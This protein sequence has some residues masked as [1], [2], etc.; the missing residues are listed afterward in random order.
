MGHYACDLTFK[1]K[2]KNIKEGQDTNMHLITGVDTVHMVNY[3]QYYKLF[4]NQ[5]WYSLEQDLILMDN[6]FTVYFSE[7]IIW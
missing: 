7:K 2:V 4:F 6:Q 3:S 5:K 1:N